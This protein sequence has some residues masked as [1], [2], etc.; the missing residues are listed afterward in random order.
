LPYTTPDTANSARRTLCRVQWVNEKGFGLFAEEAMPAGAFLCLYAGEVISKLEA[1]KRW[2]QQK[3]TFE[4]N[5]ILAIKEYIN[6]SE[7]TEQLLQT[8]VDPVY[9]GNIGRFMSTCT[10]RGRADI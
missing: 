6:T 1:Q 2:N 4:S 8:I 5:Y 9:T 7:G 3:L 10:Y